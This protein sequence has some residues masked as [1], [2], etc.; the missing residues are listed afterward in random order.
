ML[1]IK[2]VL[3]L[4]EQW[5]ACAIWLSFLCWVYLFTA[6]LLLS[7]PS[8]FSADS[9][10]QNLSSHFCLLI[11][12][13]KS[14]RKTGSVPYSEI[15]ILIH[16]RVSCFIFSPTALRSSSHLGP[17]PEVTNEISLRLSIIPMSFLLV[18]YLKTIQQ[19]DAWLLLWMWSPRLL[20]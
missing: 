18:I 6:I 13:A 4:V 8:Y 2:P 11:R 19:F 16:Y 15:L 17:S 9:H 14:L 12:L 3:V 7:I 20:I 1:K 10:T 5:I